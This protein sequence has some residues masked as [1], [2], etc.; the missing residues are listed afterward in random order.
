MQNWRTFVRERLPQRGTLRDPEEIVAELASHL[1]EVYEAARSRSFSESGA[2]DLTLQQVH[3]WDALGDGICRAKSREG[4]MSR[5]TKLF[6]MPGMA[7]L[8]AVGLALVL[9]D[10]IAILQ[11]LIWI[12][13]M[14]LLLYA[15]AYEANRL[16]RRTRLFWLPGFVSLTAA[17]I[18][19]LAVDTRY[20]PSRFFREICVHPQDLVRW[21]S[22]SPRCLYLVWL[23]AQ[24][25]FGALGALFS[26][27]AGGT[28]AAGIIAGAFPAMVIVGTYIALIPITSLI[29][30]KP[31]SFPLPSYLA[32]AALVWVVAPAIA[33]LAGAL[34]FLSGS[35]VGEAH[36]N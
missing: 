28:R 30:G 17:T 35:N 34:P 18:L 1:E 19:L 7:T 23:L 4:F 2:L 13:C 36:S 21:T 31:V 32:S 33:L 10:R 22:A 27:R 3:D 15:A 11:R 25:A 12:T 24:I 29:S 20:D 9:L 16:N 5:R 6:L 26:R 14:V 8:F